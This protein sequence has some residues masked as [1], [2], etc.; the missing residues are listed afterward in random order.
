MPNPDCLPILINQDSLQD[1]QKDVVLALESVISADQLLEFWEISAEDLTHYSKQVE[2]KRTVAKLRADMLKN[3]S[4]ARAAAMKAL[5]D[6]AHRIGQRLADP[7]LGHGAFASLVNQAY[8]IS[9]MKA[10]DA[11]VRDRASVNPGPINIQI[12]LNGKKKVLHFRRTPEAINSIVDE[13]DPVD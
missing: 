3:G 12:N 11:K 2:F 6:N 8:Q 1:F 9:G 10:D 7:E 13:S 5:T 4:I